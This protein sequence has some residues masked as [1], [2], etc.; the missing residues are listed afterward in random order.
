MTETLNELKKS[1]SEWKGSMSDLIGKTRPAPGRII[2]SKSSVRI[3]HRQWKYHQAI[4]HFSD[5]CS[6][7]ALQTFIS[8]KFHAKSVLPSDVSFFTKPRTILDHVATLNDFKL[9]NS[10]NESERVQSLLS[11][12]ADSPKTGASEDDIRFGNQLRLSASLS[13]ETLSTVL[14]IK[15]Q[16]EPEALIQQKPSAIAH[17]PTLYYDITPYYSLTFGDHTIIRYG[18]VRLDSAVID[19]TCPLLMRADVN[20]KSVTERGSTDNLNK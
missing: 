9:L 2:V 6:I 8:D 16:Y 15:V 17:I 7:L 5:D 13:S 12:L 1:A 18:G 20:Q 14:N 3:C 19:R 10:I 4:V 11:Q